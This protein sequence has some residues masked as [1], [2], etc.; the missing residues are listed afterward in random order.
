MT[1]HADALSHIREQL[2]GPGRYVMLTRTEALELVLP[3]IDARRPMWASRVHF[4]GIVVFAA[5]SLWG[6]ETF[7]QCA[8]GQHP[9]HLW[10]ETC[11]DCDRPFSYCRCDRAENAWGGWEQRPY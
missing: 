9:K 6:R 8:C 2:L 5:P 7:Q 11:P 1:N 10:R 3:N 4:N